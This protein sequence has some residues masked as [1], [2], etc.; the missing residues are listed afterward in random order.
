MAKLSAARTL[1]SGELAALTG[2]SRDALRY[3]ERRHLLPAAQRT[4]GGYRQ[5]QPEAAARVM[6]I[7]AAL[8]IGFTV[9]EL[10][11]ILSARDRGMAPCQQVYALAVEKAHVLETRIAEMEDL[12]KALRAAI[13]SWGR[14]LKATGPHKR[15]G[16]LEMFAA[17]YPET[18]K[19]ISPLVSPGLKSS[20]QKKRG[21]R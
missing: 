19:G 9:E 1:R 15:A 21:L 20:L 5:F 8:S 7:R 6:L 13:G 18:A 2:V 17:K 4:A 3:Y 16:L 11:D 14:K 10:G 12:L